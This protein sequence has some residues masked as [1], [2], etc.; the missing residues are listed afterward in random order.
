MP[1]QDHNRG[2]RDGFGEWLTGSLSLVR[3]QYL[4]LSTKKVLSNQAQR[5]VSV[6]RGSLDRVHI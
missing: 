2:A 3:S 4:G 5:K 1:R 6:P